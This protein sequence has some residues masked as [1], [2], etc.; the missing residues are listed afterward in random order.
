LRL[1]RAQK[2]HISHRAAES[3]INSPKPLKGHGASDAS[4]TMLK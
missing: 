2:S 4:K 3:F 1:E